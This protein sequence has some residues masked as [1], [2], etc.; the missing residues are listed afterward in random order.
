[1]TNIDLIQ[2]DLP[3]VV[4]G[5]TIA[6]DGTYKS[7]ANCDIDRICTDLGRRECIKDGRPHWKKIPCPNCG[8]SLSEPRASGGKKWRHCFSCNFEFEVKDD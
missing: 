8:G 2:P 1:M 5:H 7:C 4:I 3:H 6:A